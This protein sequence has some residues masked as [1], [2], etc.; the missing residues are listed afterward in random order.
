MDKPLLS[1]IFRPSSM[2]L[3]TYVNRSANRRG[4]TYEEELELALAQT[5]NLITITGGTKTGKTV[6]YRKVIDS[7]KLVELSGS[8]IQCKQDFWD[9][10]AERLSIPD[11]VTVVYTTQNTAGG[12]TGTN[13]R[14]TL[15]GILGFGISAENNVSDSKGKNITKKVTRNNT[16]IMRILIDCGYVLV[17]D[18]FHYANTEVQLYLARTLK[19]E[20][21]NG[22]KAI[23]LSL[24]HR[25]DDVVKRNP[26][27][28]GRV[29]FINLQP[30]TQEELKEIAVKGFDQ[31]GLAVSDDIIS[32]IA[33]ESA[34]SPQL[35]QSNCFYLAYLSD[36]GICTISREGAQ[37]A[38]AETAFRYPIYEDVIQNVLKGPSKGKSRRTQYLLNDGTHGDIYKLLLL[39]MC[40]DPPTLELSLEELHARMENIKSNEGNTKLPS[41]PNLSK[42]IGN[43]EKIIKESVLDPDTIDWKDGVMYIIDPFLLFFL[44]WSGWQMQ[45]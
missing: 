41:T 33:Y 27:L 22:L 17:I 16:I 39:A 13:A 23:I 20:I 12:K 10:I 6:L 30:W 9:L 29:T 2:P 32:Y 38:F 24:P 34:V 15:A 35:M 19:A 14:V 37:R 3:Y 36:K 28:V 31:L 5:G 45:I 21:F 18:D 25:L 40:A 43:A 1:E 42:N 8:Q 11:E 26:D 44:R 4:T 7:D